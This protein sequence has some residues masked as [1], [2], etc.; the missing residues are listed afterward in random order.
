MANESKIVENGERLFSLTVSI[1]KLIEA[2]FLVKMLLF[3]IT[4]LDIIEN[5]YHL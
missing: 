3:I 1:K 5:V 2:S 4:F